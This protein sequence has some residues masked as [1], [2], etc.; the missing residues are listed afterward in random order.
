MKMS[1]SVLPIVCLFQSAIM[2][3]S[4]DVYKLSA[5]FHLSSFRNL[6]VQP[7]GLLRLEFW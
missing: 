7:S 4:R 3:T 5:I 6:I 1:L 2:C